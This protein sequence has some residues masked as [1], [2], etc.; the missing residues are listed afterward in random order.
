MRREPKADPQE[1]Q[2]LK[3]LLNQ[4][5]L[6]EE[7]EEEE[8]EEYLTWRVLSALLIYRRWTSYT[9]E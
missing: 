3:V 4:K 9:V 8:E 2:P 6:G 1:L 5:E 7:P